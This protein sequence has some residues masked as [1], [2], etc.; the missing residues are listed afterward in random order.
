MRVVAFSIAAL[1]TCIATVAN[2]HEFWIDPEQSQ[3]AMGEDIVADLRVGQNFEGSSYVY[4]PSQFRR[5]DIAQGNM[6]RAV[7]GRAGDNPALS[8]KLTASGLAIIVHETTDSVLTYG[9]F[10]KFAAFVEHKDAQWALAAHR[11]RNLPMDG[12]VEVYS[13]YAK[14]LV[15]VGDGSGMDRPVGLETEIVAL[16]NPYTD[17]VTAGLPVQVLYQGTPRG[18][19]QVEIFAKDAV[20][21]VVVSTVKADGNGQA[22]VPVTRGHRYMLDSVVLREPSAERAEAHNAVWESLWANLTFSVPN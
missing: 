3:V 22:I 5:F 12:I 13:R 9:E 11:D 10:A 6:M 14:S 20:G 19:A 4:L 7:A 21:N 15:A 17:D 8:D 18:G 1:L 16:A 2:A